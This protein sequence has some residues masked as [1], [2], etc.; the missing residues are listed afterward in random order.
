MQHDVER[1]PGREV[2]E[3]RG[4]ALKR[5]DASAR[6][7]EEREQHREHRVEDDGE[8][9]VEQRHPGHRLLGDRGIGVARLGVGALRGIGIP[10]RVRKALAGGAERVD[11]R[12]LAQIGKGVGRCRA[13]ELAGDYRQFG[14][15]LGRGDVVGELRIG[16]LGERDQILVDLRRPRR[17]EIAIGLVARNHGVAGRPIASTVDPFLATRRA[18]RPDRRPQVTAAGQ[19]V[20]RLEAEQHVIEHAL[21][22]VLVEIGAELGVGDLEGLR[23][24]EEPGTINHAVIRELEGIGHHEHRL[25]GPR[26]PVADL[27]GEGGHDPEAQRDVVDDRGRESRV[28]AVGDLDRDG[29]H[30]QHHVDHGRLQEPVEPG[31]PVEREGDD[32]QR[33][34]EPHH[35]HDL[36]H[37]AVAPAPRPRRDRV[38]GV[39][40]VFAAADRE[41]L[42]HGP[43]PYLSPCALKPRPNFSDALIRGDIAFL[44]V[45]SS[46][47]VRSITR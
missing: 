19:R 4:V 39:D 23:L 17:I 31:P 8:H 27:A 33:I 9:D 16:L 43:L 28:D 47:W 32:Q 34:G 42:E 11:H 22:H 5:R 21:L 35:H 45:L 18:A 29:R 41:D 7:E 30:Q 44:S 38:K 6:K 1:A 2:E 37:R 3:T 26:H 24:V 15:E 46:I 36:K 12:H 40:D 25:G 14:P 10:A 20:H 13:V